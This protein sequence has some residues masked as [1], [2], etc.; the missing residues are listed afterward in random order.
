[1]K[2]GFIAVTLLGLLATRVFF[3]AKVPTGSMLETIQ[4]NDVLLVKR[5]DFCREVK[6]GDICVFR[7]SQDDV[8]LVKRLIGEPGDR[9]VYQGTKI[10]V[11]GEELKEDYVSSDREIYKTFT[12]PKDSYFFLGDNRADSNDSAVWEYPYVSKE[13][14]VGVVVK[15]IA[16]TFGDLK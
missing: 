10:V 5:I 4:L 8:L 7:R 13:N 1:M 6:R 14:L 9:V 15:R 2:W 12:V 3:I 11:N 16:P